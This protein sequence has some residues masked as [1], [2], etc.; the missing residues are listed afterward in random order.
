MV[1]QREPQPDENVV[2]DSSHQPATTGR[3]T[4]AGD[5]SGFPYGLAIPA[6]S[7]VAAAEHTLEI[8][9]F[10]HVALRV[11]NIRQAEE[12]YHEFLEMDVVARARRSAQGWDVISDDFDWIEGLRTGYYPELVVLRNGPISLFLINAG[13]GAVMNEPKLAHLGL[14]VS[15][16]T[17]ATLRGMVLIRSYPVIQDDI[18]AFRFRDPYG[19]TWHLTDTGTQHI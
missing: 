5:V 4:S 1:D 9:A 11:A 10:D 18:H 16:E 8:E 7:M 14:R 12:F 13:R 6:N 3:T 2:S 19:V 17:L 15:T